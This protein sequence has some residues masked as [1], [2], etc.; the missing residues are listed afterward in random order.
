MKGDEFDVAWTTRHDVHFQRSKVALATATYLAHPSGTAEA[1]I[2]T[3][4]SVT[5]VGAVL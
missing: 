1:C 2:N 5:A 4:A 3:D